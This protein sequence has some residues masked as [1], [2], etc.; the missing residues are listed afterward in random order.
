MADSNG[1][2]AGARVVSIV[3]ILLMEGALLWARR[4]ALPKSKSSSTTNVP[5]TTMEEPEQS[6]GV[7]PSWFVGQD[8]SVSKRAVTMPIVVTHYRHG[9]AP[10]YG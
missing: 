9:S 6:V 8:G 4:R 10:K 3:V 1:K 2:A 5:L 7:T